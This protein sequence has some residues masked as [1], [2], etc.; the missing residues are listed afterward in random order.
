MKEGIVILNGIHTFRITQNA[1]QLILQRK[2]YC[3]QS[4]WNSLLLHGVLLV[5]GRVTLFLPV[6]LRNNIFKVKDNKPVDVMKVFILKNSGGRDG[7]S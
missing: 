3:L 7:S 1:A 4:L 2:K 6:F 5:T